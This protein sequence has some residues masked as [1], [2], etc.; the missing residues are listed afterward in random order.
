MWFSVWVVNSYAAKRGDPTNQITTSTRVPVQYMCMKHD[1]CKLE[2][3][4]A[5]FT[6][7]KFFI[8]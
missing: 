6:Q 3:S 7:V 4:W 8:E 1:T 2:F 5:L